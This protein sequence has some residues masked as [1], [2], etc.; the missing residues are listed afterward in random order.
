MNKGYDELKMRGIDKAKDAAYRAA[1]S[2]FKDHDVSRKGQRIRV[3]KTPKFCAKHCG[4]EGTV[5]H[6]R[7]SDSLGLHFVHVNLDGDS[8]GPYGFHCDELVFL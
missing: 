5:D 4:K 8:E 2:E 3:I 7:R 6:E 1:G